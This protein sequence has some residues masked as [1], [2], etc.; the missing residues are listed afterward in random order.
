MTFTQTT[1]S[2]ALAVLAVCSCAGALSG[3]GIFGALS[4][5]GEAVESEKMVEK[6]ASYR[7]LENKTVAVIVN[8]DRGILYEYPTIVPQVVSNVA[9][10]VRTKVSGAKVLAPSE[11]VGWCFR[12]PSWPTMPLGQIAEELGVDRVVVVNIFEFRLNPPG[13]RWIWEG[14]AAANVGIIEREA[15]DPDM[16]AEEYS[17]TVTFPKEKD[18]SRESEPEAKILFGLTASFTQAINK[19]FYDHMEAKYPDRKLNQ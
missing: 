1:S 17:V 10:G 11:S 12:T 13:N 18:I 2:R 7:G 9:L 15:M 8:A 6:L 3:C 14:V 19:L 4:K 5:V 16:Y